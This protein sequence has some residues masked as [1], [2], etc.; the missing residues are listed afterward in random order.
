MIYKIGLLLLFCILLTELWINICLFALLAFEVL[1]EKGYKRWFWPAFS[2]CGFFFEISY[3]CF[4]GWYIGVLSEK[5][6][7]WFKYSEGVW[8][9]T[10]SSVERIFGDCC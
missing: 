4:L 5:F 10:S 1:S 9:C 7:S 8:L 3:H 2:V 6:P